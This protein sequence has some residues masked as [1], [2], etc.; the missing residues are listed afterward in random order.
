MHGIVESKMTSFDGVRETIS[1]W[2]LQPI[3]VFVCF[4]VRSP[5]V[6]FAHSFCLF[7]LYPLTLHRDIF[8]KATALRFKKCNGWLHSCCEGWNTCFASSPAPKHNLWCSWTFGVKEG[9]K[10]LFIISR[11]CWRNL[12]AIRIFLAALNLQKM[13][14]GASLLAV[15]AKTDPHLLNHSVWPRDSDNHDGPLISMSN[16]MI[17][18]VMLT[19]RRNGFTLCGGIH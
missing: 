15:A 3:C 12:F 17:V 6:T 11:F 5:C 16:S 1:L 13:G 2:P 19:A 4:C 8:H 14:H 10:S 18:I 9:I 7:N